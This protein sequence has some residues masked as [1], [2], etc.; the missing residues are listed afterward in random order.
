MSNDQSN[1]ER[2][3]PLV[4]EIITDLKSEKDKDGYNSLTKIRA[5]QTEIVIT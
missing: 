1:N 5:Q 2:F 4:Q 3:I